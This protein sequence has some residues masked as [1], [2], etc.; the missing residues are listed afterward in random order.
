MEPIAQKRTTLGAGAVTGCH[1]LAR[2]GHIRDADDELAR[3]SVS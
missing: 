3:A 2:T 1:I